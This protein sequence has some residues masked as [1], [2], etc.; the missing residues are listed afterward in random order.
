MTE[1]DRAYILDWK[2]YVQYPF[3]PVKRH[4]EKSPSIEL[5]VIVAGHPTTVYLV[6]MWEIK[7]SL[8]D[9]PKIEYESVDKL[10]ADGWVVD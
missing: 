10:L 4:S 2:G 5:G 7:G 8:K 9:M 6:D 3:C 1:I